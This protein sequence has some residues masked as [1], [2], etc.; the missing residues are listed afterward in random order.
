MVHII[1]IIYLFFWM[2]RVDSSYELESSIV[3]KTAAKPKAGECHANPNSGIAGMTLFTI[4]CSKFQDV[5]GDNSLLYMYYEQY[6]ND[7]NGYGNN[8]ILC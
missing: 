8:I 1:K 5:Y 2:V 3:I 6:E 7:E 4:T